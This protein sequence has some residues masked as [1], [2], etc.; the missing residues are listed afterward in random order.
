M[1][2]Q[3]NKN[4]YIIT[5]APASGKTTFGY[6]LATEINACFLDSDQVTEGLIQASLT[7]MNRDPGDRDSDFYKQTFRDVVYETLLTLAEINIR[8]VPVVIA[9][10][11]TKEIQS[12][13]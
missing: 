11:F 6:K 8:N 7:A 5:G 4:L 3:V 10:P 13:N 1:N 9:A 12:L 2:F